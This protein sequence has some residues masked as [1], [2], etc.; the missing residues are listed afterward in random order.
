MKQSLIIVLFCR[1]PS[2]QAATN[3]N[4]IDKFERKSPKNYF[5][6]QNHK[7]AKEKN[8]LSST[9]NFFSV[10]KCKEQKPKKAN[11]KYRDRDR[12]GECERRE[13]KTLTEREKARFILNVEW[14][15]KLHKYTAT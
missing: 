13:C 3:R 14:K 12:K 15:K 2:Q 5:F 1:R 7:I 10:Y 8:C 9:N 4:V 11:V 6:E